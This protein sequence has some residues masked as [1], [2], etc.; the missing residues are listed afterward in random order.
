MCVPVC[1]C[2]PATGIRATEG[3]NHELEKEEEEK[4]TCM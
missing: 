4:K 2:V 1:V 3:R